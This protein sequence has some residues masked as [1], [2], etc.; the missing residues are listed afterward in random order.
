MTMK[1]PAVP[2]C[3]AEQILAVLPSALE[4]ERLYGIDWKRLLFHKIWRDKPS[5]PIAAP[6]LPPH[7]E[8]LGPNP[9]HWPD[10]AGCRHSN[11]QRHLCFSFC[12]WIYRRNTEGTRSCLLMSGII[13]LCSPTIALLYGFFAD[14]LKDLQEEDREAVVRDLFFYVAAIFLLLF[15]KDRIVYKFQADVPALGVCTHLR[16]VLMRA[17]QNES[18]HHIAQ[19]PGASS[20]LLNSTLH[21]AVYNV[22]YNVFMFAQ[23]LSGALGSTAVVMITL[24]RDDSVRNN[25][26]IIFLILVGLTVLPYLVT[27]II[28][29]ARRREAVEL[30]Q[31]EQVWQLRYCALAVHEPSAASRP[32]PSTSSDTVTTPGRTTEE[33]EALL[34]AKGDAA[35][36]YMQRHF[37]AFFVRYLTRDLLMAV[38]QLIHV[39]IMLIAGLEVIN[40]QMKF[41]VLITLYEVSKAKVE[42]GGSFIKIALDLPEGY[43]AIQQIADVINNDQNTHVKQPCEGKQTVDDDA[44]PKEKQK[45]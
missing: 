4:Q 39:T 3:T 34:Q 40:H 25:R 26:S 14:E 23:T 18:P 43:A 38:L 21:T 2:N 44:S 24:A 31:M 19:A 5:P 16:Q 9:G 1:D 13:G 27:A 28:F 20:V 10:G 22:W 17:L 42:L 8:W 15:G 37:H 36:V 7:A 29:S 11:G 32:D 35:H 45:I 6:V 41:G 30:A 33:S 12:R